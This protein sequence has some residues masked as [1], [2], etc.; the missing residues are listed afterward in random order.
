MHKVF[1]DT[2]ELGA[3]VAIAKV[4]TRLVLSSRQ[5]AEVLDGLWNSLQNDVVESLFKSTM[6]KGEHVHLRTDPSRLVGDIIQSL[7]D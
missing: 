3:L 4:V 6:V 1:N 2:V 7:G 5:S